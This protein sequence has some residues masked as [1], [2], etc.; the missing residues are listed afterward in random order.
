VPALKPIMIAG[1]GLAGLSLGIGLRQKGIPVTIYE[2]GHYPRH[3]VCGEFISGRGLEV[4]AELGL[5]ERLVEAGATFART[6]AFFLGHRGSPV[7][8]LPQPAL[9]L[10]RY[11][12]DEQLARHFREAG[13]ELVEN[14]R[15]R[16]ERHDEGFVRASGRRLQT[17]N[18]DARWL[19]LK[20]HARQVPL[21][22]DLEMH[23]TRDGYVGFCRLPGGE[24]NI[25]GLFRRPRNGTESLPPWHEL[26][27]GSPGTPLHER[28]A[29]AVIDQSSFCSVAGFSLQPRRAAAQGKCAIGD[30]LT[31]IPPVTGNGMSMAFEA[32]SMAIG[33]LAAFSRG[34]FAWARAK[35]AIAGACD[36]AFARR[37]AA[38]RWLQWMMFAPL[39]RT[40]A[41]AP[42]LRSD[43][44]WRLL[45][46]RTR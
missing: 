5:R 31:M 32:A 13:G 35:E 46:A 8:P 43:S 10:S 38:A 29:G 15:F 42:V 21:A 2:A 3:R 40:S 24:V 12:L 17:G 16:E 11:N 9:C 22:A 28:M 37:L 45:F 6:A 41:G 18:G 14:H 19:G 20:V 26:L 23:A 4:L 44:L 36:A 33:P 7:R 34:E 1:G 27:R 25:C 30:A 39:L